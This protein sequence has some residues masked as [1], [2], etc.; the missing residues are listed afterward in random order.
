VN[1]EYGYEDHYPY[2]W[3]EGRKWPARIADNRRRIAWE[4]T[5]A[6]GYQT[7][8]ERANV[9]GYGGW[10]TG[11]GNKEMTMLQGYAHVREFFERLPWW[12]L[13]P[14]TNVVANGTAYCLA[15]PGA[16]YIVYL[17]RG[18]TV[19]LQFARGEYKARWFNPRTGKSTRI[20]TVRGDSWIS[21]SAP[22]GDDWVLHLE[23][24]N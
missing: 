11:Y 6:S 10:I 21:P 12:K 18:G 15:E 3:G 5:M 23:G 14:A 7:T 8:G 13:E 2:P 19:A 1:E 22:D 20:A 9:P 24:A 17:P 4:V 16:T